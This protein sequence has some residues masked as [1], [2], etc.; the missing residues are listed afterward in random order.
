MNN[1]GG[2]NAAVFN[3]FSYEKNNQIWLDSFSEMTKESYNN[4]IEFH[5]EVT[6]LNFTALRNCT[7]MIGD[8]LFLIP[9]QSIRS[10]SSIDYERV[11]I[12]RGKGSMVKNQTNREMYVEV[13]LFF[14]NDA[15]INGIPTEVE[16]PNGTKLTYYMNGLRGLLAQFKLAPYLP[17]ENQFINDVLGI[18][19]VSLVNLTMS[20][21]EGIPR[22]LRATLTMRDFNYRI[23]MPDIPID[24]SHNQV[25]ELAE[26]NPIFAKCIN[27]EIFRYYYQK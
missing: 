19:A 11:G 18:E 8:T 21:V 23:Y 26:M 13:D 5:K 10:M 3:L 2:S 27:W 4:R 6:G 22:L 9:P 16:M 12:M 20:T 15:G 24:Y 25:S 1:L 17:I 14:Y 7:M